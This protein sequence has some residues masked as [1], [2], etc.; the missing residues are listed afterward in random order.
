[1]A[2]IPGGWWVAAAALLSGACNAIIGVSDLRSDPRDAASAIDA[3]PGTVD[4][5]PGDASP[6]DARPCLAAPAL[7]GT[8]RDFHSTHPDFEHY[9]GTA[10]GLV[11][12]QLGTDGTPD[13]APAGATSV[14]TGPAEFAQWYHDVTDVN[15]ALPLTLPL[16]ANALGNFAYQNTAFFPI[17]G[18]GFGNEGFPHNYSF[19][20][21][22]HASFVYEPGAS[23]TF[24]GD[25]DVWVFVDGH[26]V[27]DLGGVHAALTATAD[28]DSNPDLSLVPGHRYRLDLF[29]AERHTSMSNYTFTTTI[30][31][32]VAP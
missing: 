15:L 1:M 31:C 13:Y 16:T 8:I 32:F 29:Q 17:D 11:K 18:A 4:S 30:G 20:T 24:N 3:P 2:R 12:P 22:T 6:P 26:L 9:T 7:I 14:T 10:T 28:L 19:T 21:A 5:S 27:I 23:V 25:D